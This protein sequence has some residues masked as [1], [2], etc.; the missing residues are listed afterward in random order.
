MKLM[1]LEN[2]VW[3]WGLSSSKYVQEAIRN[4]KEY[5]E[6]KLP[7]FYKLTCL[8]PNPLYTDYQ[9]ELDTHLNYHKTCLILPGGK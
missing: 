6:E 1:Q 2:G 9:P 5:V 3:A 7:K 4:C 8:A